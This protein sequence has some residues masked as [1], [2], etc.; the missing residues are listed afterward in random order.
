LYAQEHILRPPPLT[1]MGS[2]QFSSDV[3]LYPDLGY[4]FF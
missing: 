3:K 1:V 4:R 2:N